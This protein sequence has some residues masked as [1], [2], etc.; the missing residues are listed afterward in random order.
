MQPSG[1]GIVRLTASST[2]LASSEALT[3]AAAAMLSARE[4]DTEL[5]PQPPYL[6]EKR[7]HETRSRT[8][9][10]KRSRLTLV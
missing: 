4:I 10:T 2:A 8:D 9:V 7:S 6:C 5:K 3:P 1:S